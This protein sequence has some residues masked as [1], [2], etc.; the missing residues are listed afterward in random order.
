VPPRQLVTPE[1]LTTVISIWQ[2][3]S[4][5]HTYAAAAAACWCGC[6]GRVRGLLL[7]LLLLGFAQHVGPCY[8]ICRDEFSDTAAGIVPTSSSSSSCMSCTCALIAA[9]STVSQKCFCAHPLQVQGLR[10]LLQDLGRVVLPL[11][12][13][14]LPVLLLLLV[15]CAAGVVVYGQHLQLCSCCCQHQAQVSRQGPDGA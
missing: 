8:S 12:L 3:H 11:L 5:H 4:S 2:P 13:L 1:A 7:L 15:V 9:Y 10:L 14:L 6:C